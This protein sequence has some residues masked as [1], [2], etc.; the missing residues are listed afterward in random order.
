MSLP[1]H[2]SNSSTEVGEQCLEYFPNDPNAESIRPTIFAHDEVLG[3]FSRYTISTEESFVPERIE[4][5]DSTSKRRRANEDP[6]RIVVLGKDRLRYKVLKYPTA[7]P[8]N[9]SEENGDISM[10]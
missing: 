2:A 7:V 8:H 5:R 1:Y 6:R 3:R 4:I 9:I 10:S